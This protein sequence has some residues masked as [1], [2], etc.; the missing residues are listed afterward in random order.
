MFD[1]IMIEFN[2][3]RKPNIIS[4]IILFI[5]YLLLAINYFVFDN[6]ALALN[7]LVAVFFIL[8]LITVVSL[9]VFP[10]KKTKKIKQG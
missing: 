10:Y 7:F 2:S 6:N 5:T 4:I 3:K 9:L 8:I 1:I